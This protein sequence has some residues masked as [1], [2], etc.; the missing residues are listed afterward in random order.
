LTVCYEEQKKHND[1]AELLLELL[2]S[3]DISES[4][5]MFLKQH[6]AEN[7]L[8][9]S[10]AKE[11]L[12]YALSACEGRH[13]QQDALYYESC[14]LVADIY[15]ALDDV[16]EAELY[17]EDIPLK[18]PSKFSSENTA[19]STPTLG[20][21]FASHKTTRRL[22]NI[23]LL[24]TMESHFKAVTS[25]AFSPDGYWLASGSDDNTVRLWEAAS[26]R[27]VR[28]LEGHSDAVLSVSFSRDSRW[29]A[30]GSADTTVRVWEVASGTQLQTLTGHAGWVWSV[31][32]SW[33]GH[34]LASGSGDKTVRV[35]NP[36]SGRLAET[37][38]N[39]SS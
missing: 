7:Y 27:L 19:E 32:F 5:T 36:A 23:R 17:L 31:S 9:D 22:K 14:L 18:Q 10:K 16:A 34:W 28:A 29:L 39:Y 12:P 30:S 24:Q 15:K 37:L 33:N 4:Q 8:K 11:A 6:L 38:Q 20:L 1:A 21:G 35:W 25:I 3:E 13:S 26:T 2:K